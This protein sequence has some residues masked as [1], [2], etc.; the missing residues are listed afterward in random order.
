MK[1]LPLL[2]LLILTAPSAQAEV[3]YPDQK[4]LPNLEC[5]FAQSNKIKFNLDAP[6]MVWQEEA[7]RAFPWQKLYRGEVNETLVAGDGL[8][9]KLKLEYSDSYFGKSVNYII[10]EIPKGGY[11]FQNVVSISSFKEFNFKIFQVFKMI[12]GFDSLY[13]VECKDSE[14][15]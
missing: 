5:T 2:S 9:L 8:K 4:N 11:V 12:D 15:K 3:L 13:T 10:E 6:K 1:L 14:A 7:N